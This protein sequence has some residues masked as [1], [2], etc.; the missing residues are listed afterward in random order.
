M[1]VAV[2]TAI[3]LPRGEFQRLEAI[4]KRT[5][6]SRS[7]IL[8]VAFR[9]W[10]KLKEQEILEQR[11]VAGYLRQPEMAADVEGLYRVS[12]SEFAQGQW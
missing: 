5:R 11:Y 8:L 2:K 1:A 12:L 4:R 10:L 7:R 9:A 3:S 6:Q